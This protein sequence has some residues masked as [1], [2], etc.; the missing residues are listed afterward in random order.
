[1]KMAHHCLG[2]AQLAKLGEQME[3]PRVH[4][5]IGIEANPAIATI[6]QPGRQRHPQLASRRLLSLALMQ[7]QLN[8]MK[9]SLAHD[10][11]QAEQQTV[12]IGARIVHAL[13][14]GDQHSKQRAQFQELMPIV[15]VARQPRGIQAQH[16]PRLPEA[17]LG[18]QPL[19]AAAA[20]ARRT[21][22]PEVV[23]NDLNPFL[24]PAEQGCT[25]D[26]PILQLG[27]LLMLTDL[28]GGRLAHVN[29]GQLGAMRRRHRAFQ[30]EQH[31]HRDAPRSNRRRRLR[32]A[33]TGV[34]VPPASPAVVVL[35]A[36]S[37]AT[38][39]APRSAV[40]PA[41]PART[42][43]SAVWPDVSSNLSP[44][45]ES[46]ARTYSAKGIRVRTDTRGRSRFGLA[47][48]VE[49]LRS[50]AFCGTQRCRPS[51]RTTRIQPVRRISPLELT[52]SG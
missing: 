3:Q 50:V 40:D 35:S 11:G 28:A 4:F 32:P 20:V 23:I 24:G 37:S 1:M 51:E 12:M 13:A 7:P 2:A 42:A 30:I 6:R 10:P 9:F 21:G 15:V 31:V 22:L 41:M 16:Q 48:Q 8:L 39:S 44:K 52:S 27:A 45:A 38:I 36:S 14:I 29:I 46:L 18:D 26:Q 17:N 47:S 49:T 25:I 33:L 34:A 5:F 43:G 19:E